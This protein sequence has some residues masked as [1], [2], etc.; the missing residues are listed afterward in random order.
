MREELSKSSSAHYIATK[1]L[2]S[3]G[4]R[5]PHIKQRGHVTLQR[6]IERIERAVPGAPLGRPGRVGLERAPLRCVLRQPGILPA[7]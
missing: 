5:E 7:R 1:A 6:A 4:N 3:Q 2:C